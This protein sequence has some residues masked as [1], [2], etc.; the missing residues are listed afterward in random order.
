MLAV[1]SFN[2]VIHQSEMRA[3]GRDKMRGGEG[4]VKFLHFVEDG[5]WPHL[6]AAAQLTLEPGV[7]IGKHAHSAETEY[8]VI[9]EG[10]GVTNDD[11]AEIPVAKGDVMI[12]GRGAS[13]S[14]K[15]TGSVPL[16]M[17]SFIINN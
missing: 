7:S 3:E 16:V 17:N 11:G 15:N 2:M 8:L 14:V 4:T 6:K 12:T 5:A 1:R 13:H 9:L 10:S